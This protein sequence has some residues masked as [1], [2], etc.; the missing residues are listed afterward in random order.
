MSAHIGTVHTVTDLGTGTPDG[1]KFLRDDGVW[2]TPAGGPG[3]AS[4]WGDI[5]GTLADQTDLQ[6]ALD[7][8]EVAGQGAVQVAQH[9]ADSTDIHPQYQ[10]ESEKNA[11]SG[12]AGLDASSK[13]TGSQQV[14][15]TGANTACVGNDARLSDARTPLAH[16]HNATDINAGTVATARLGSGTANNTTYLR[17]D[18]TWATPA[19]SAATVTAGVGTS[20]TSSSTQQITHN[21]GR[22]PVVIRIVGKDTFLANAAALPATGSIGLWCSTGNL[23]IYQ[24]YDPTTVTAAEPAATSVAYAVRQQTGVGNF[25]TGVIGNVG[26]TTFDIVWTETGTHTAQVYLWEAS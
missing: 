16:N 12:Y 6:T 22:T 21:L 3:G 19:S 15:G 1:T 24:P 2:A 14:Y 4:A 17:G 13:L 11:A 7:G 18:Q 8:K 20:P 23:C 9:E 26:A 25:A 10:K 5:T